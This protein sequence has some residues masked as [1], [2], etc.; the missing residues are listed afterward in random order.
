MTL[1]TD[2]LESIGLGDPEE[3]RGTVN[4]VGG[5]GHVHDER[6]R[7]RLEAFIEAHPHLT[8][9]VLE[10]RDH[11]GVSRTAL[12]AYLK[13]KYFTSGG[14]G[15]KP[16]NPKNSQVEPRIRRYL[17]RE[18]GMGAA[19]TDVGFVRTV[20]T[21]QFEFACDTAI[22]ENIIVV[23]Y[24]S[25]GHGKSVAL[26]QYVLNKLTTP[27]IRIL[28]SRNITP[29]YFVK[30]LAR[31]LGIKKQACIPELE[32]LIADQLL[33]RKRVIFVDQANYL[34][35][36]GIGTI[37]HLWDRAKVG[38]VLAGTYKL[39][40]LFT[41][42]SDSEDIRS[43]LSSRVALFVPLMGLSIGEVKSIAERSLGEAATADVVAEIWNAI[44]RNKYADGKPTQ[45]ASFRNL[46]FLL[47]RLKSLLARNADELAAGTATPAEMVRAAAGKLMLG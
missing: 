20:L 8:T 30:R 23:A 19:S 35:D 38:I 32:D 27:P 41:T 47:P 36:R 33:K 15:G 6:L 4:V 1:S 24:G 2:H 43:Q 44:A 3:N 40:E 7:Q 31:E 12:D 37:T 46:S 45:A 29:G 9:S 34:D 39:Y 28:C 18:E 5:S 21:N 17:D 25:P 13:A 16:V 11:I 22:E 14:P 10:R 42:L 26:Q